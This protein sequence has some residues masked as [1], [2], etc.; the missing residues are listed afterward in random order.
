MVLRILLSVAVLILPGCHVSPAPS[1]PLDSEGQPAQSRKQDLSEYPEKGL[2]EVQQVQPSEGTSTYGFNDIEVDDPCAVAYNAPEHCRGLT[3]GHSN[4][5]LQ[6][7]QPSAVF[8][9]QAITPQVIDPS[10]FDAEKTADEIGRG[11]AQL[12]SSRA[13]GAELLFPERP[14]N[15]GQEDSNDP[16]AQSNFPV[17]PPDPSED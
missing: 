6:R 12:N 17:Y 8:R 15:Q 2:L 14:E 9:L 7:R 3:R 4:L 13:L 10:S 11:R 5:N 16:P 1:G